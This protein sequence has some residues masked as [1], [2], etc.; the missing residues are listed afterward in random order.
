MITVNGET[1]ASLYIDKGYVVINREW[2]AGDQIVLS[3]DMP[4]EVVTADSRV[5][6]N[7]GKRAIQRGPLVYCVEEADNRDDFDRIALSPETTYQAEFRSSLLNGVTAVTAT[8][9][10]RSFTLI[11]YYAWDNREAGKMKVWMDYK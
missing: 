9:N 7:A 2:K 1:I 3:F 5:M 6:A 4:V 11:P 8:G 10:G